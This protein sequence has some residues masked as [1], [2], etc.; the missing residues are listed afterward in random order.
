ML[1]DV[2]MTRQGEGKEGGQM[3]FGGEALCTGAQVLCRLS[4][5][6]WTPSLTHGALVAA[7]DT[8][9]QAPVVGGQAAR[10]FGWMRGEVLSRPDA[11]DVRAAY[12]EYLA[13]SRDQL[14]GWLCDGSLGCGA[15]VVS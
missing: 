10:G 2:T 9:L 14:R 15:R 7:V 6:A 13:E 1:D 12:E 5:D 8:Y 4:L 3:I 11:G